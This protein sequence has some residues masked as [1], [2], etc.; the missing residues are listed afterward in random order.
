MSR[1]VAVVGGIGAGKSVV[2]RI[3]RAEGFRVYDCD[4]EAK[5]LMDSDR[6]IHQKLCAAIHPDAVR[7]GVVDRKLIASIVFSDTHKLN[8]L[9]GIVHAA[10]RR[11]F[12]E[13]VSHRTGEQILFIETAILYQSRLDQSVDEVWEVVAPKELRIQRV[14]H[15]NLLSRKEV[16][17]RIKSQESNVIERTPLPTTALINDGVMPLLPQIKKALQVMDA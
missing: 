9:N 1:I 13:W 8:E 6:D 14:M 3:L 17:N 11:H 16:E 7:E 4:S 5:A 15:R 2:S 12:A 10:V